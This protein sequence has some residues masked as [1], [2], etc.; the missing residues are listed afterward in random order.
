MRRALAYAL[1]GTGLALGLTAGTSA[2]AEGGEPPP[3]HGHILV[4]GLQF[5]EEENLVGYR[6]C[7]D[8]ANNRALPLHAHHRALHTG[9]GG[10]ALWAAG[11][12]VAPTAP[13]WPG[14]ENCASFA[15]MFGPPTG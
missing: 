6:K 13:L 2:W 4:L 7:I 3:P 14:L 11:H 8:L 10:E 15:E 1:A 9:R 12:G 5:D